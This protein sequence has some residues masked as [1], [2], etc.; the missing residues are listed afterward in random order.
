MNGYEFNQEF[1]YDSLSKKI[2]EDVPDLEIEDFDFNED[3][4]PENPIDD[5]SLDDSESEELTPNERDEL[6]I[7]NE[8]LVHFVAKKFQN[9]GIDHDE[10][11]GIAY[12]GFTKALNGYKKNRGVKFT[13]YAY[14]CMF[15][16]ILFYLRKEKKH[17]DKTV[18]MSNP[19]TT[20]KD[21]HIFDE[22][23]RISSQIHN[24]ERS[25]EDTAIIGQAVEF[26]NEIIDELS[27]TEQ[28]IIKSR[29]GLHGHKIK[30]QKEIADE[31]K[32][33]QANISK[34]E[35]TILTKISKILTARY[36]IDYIEL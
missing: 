6:T 5:V 33:S 12:L 23:S 2:I 11:T 21:G 32:M 14:N 30:T 22:E 8:A 34:L 18:P 35:K 4:L 27:E 15:N 3:E 25:L 9:T 28:L 13:T 19:V 17:R 10:L 31:T 36:G 20:D 26:L 1:D 7:N 24:E 16:E 29:Y